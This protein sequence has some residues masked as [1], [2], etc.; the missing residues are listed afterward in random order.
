MNKSV[1]NEW[2]SRVLSRASETADLEKS[3]TRTH[4]VAILLSTYHGQHFLAEQLESFIAQTHTN[5]RVWASDDGSEDKT[6]AILQEF[7]KKQAEKLFIDHGPSTGFVANFLSLTC[8]QNIVADYYAYSDQDDIWEADKL[9][10]AVAWLNNVAPDMPALYCSRT[11]LVDVNN[12]EIGLSPLFSKPPSFANALMQN[13]G[14]GNTMVFNNAARMLLSEAGQSVS[15]VSHDW[16]AYIVISGCGGEI[17]YDHYPSVRYRQHQHNIVGMNST[18][19]ARL[20][21]I[22]MLCKGRFKD[23]S[24]SNIEALEKLQHKL[25]P[26]N[27]DI[28]YQFAK[29]RN[30][31]LISRLI[32]LKKSG[33]Y[34]QTLLGN[35]GLFVAALFKKI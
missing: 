20:N 15:V 5:W 31:G 3:G 30:R 14:G 1:M 24:D 34:R 35:I 25:T 17:Y 9:E 4:H 21:R 10:R 32:G 6:M 28:L 33:I 29:A 22:R 16:W 8:Q 26:Q 2:E 23:W 12:H 18:W 19:S 7:Q 27:R 13:I 11:R